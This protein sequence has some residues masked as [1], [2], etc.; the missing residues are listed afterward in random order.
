LLK[1]KNQ[2]QQKPDKNSKSQANTLII[3][4]SKNQPKKHRLKTK[5]QEKQI[6]TKSLRH[7][8]NSQLN[9]TFAF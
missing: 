9:I 8:V 5:R 2:S 4:P 7:A 6:K 3:K 1:A